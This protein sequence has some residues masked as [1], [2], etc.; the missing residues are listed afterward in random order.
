LT[1][2]PRS[3]QAAGSQALIAWTAKRTMLKVLS[4]LMVTVRTND[5]RA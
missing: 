2:T 3:P 4:S 1:I 5:A